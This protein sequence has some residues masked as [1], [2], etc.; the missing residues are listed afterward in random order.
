D[1]IAG[2]AAP[3]EHLAERLRLL[4]QAQPQAEKHAAERQSDPNTYL[5]R[6]PASINGV[7]EQEPKPKQQQ[8]DA[9]LVEPPFAAAH[10]IEIN[11]RYGHAHG[12]A[13]RRQGWRRQ[14]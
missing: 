1:V 9:D 13:G 11:V 12:L 2:D 3:Q 6:Q 14:M 7:L 8:A 4:V 10:H 5:L